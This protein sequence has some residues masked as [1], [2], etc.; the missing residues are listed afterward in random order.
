MIKK[1]LIQMKEEL[2]LMLF[3]FGTFDLNI[4]KQF[5]IMFDKIIVG[6]SE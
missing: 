5:N 2:F 6:A 1:K 4:L 3:L